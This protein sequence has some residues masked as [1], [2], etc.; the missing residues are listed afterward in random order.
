MEAGLTPTHKSGLNDTERKIQGKLTE[1]HAQDIEG[2]LGRRWGKH[3][4]I[5]THT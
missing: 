5:N 1:S 4:D 3:T 2:V